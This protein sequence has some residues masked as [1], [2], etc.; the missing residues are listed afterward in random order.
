MPQPF[1]HP[2]I[3][4]KMPSCQVDLKTR[5]NYT[6][7]AP[8]PTAAPALLRTMAGN[9]RDKNFLACRMQQ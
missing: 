8:K 5:K 9:L 4:K 2:S 6:A 1:V 3:T 7:D